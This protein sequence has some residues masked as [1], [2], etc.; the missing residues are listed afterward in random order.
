M[1][2]ISEKSL[3]IYPSSGT[4]LQEVGELIACGIP[5]AFCLTMQSYTAIIL[6]IKQLENMAR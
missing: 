4:V 3:T 1:V 5:L 6:I 2:A